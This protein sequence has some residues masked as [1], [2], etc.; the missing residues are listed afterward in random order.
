MTSAPVLPS[1]S[2]TL[3]LPPLGH[4]QPEPE[5]EPES[6]ESEAEPEE[7]EETVPELSTSQYDSSIAGRSSQYG[8]SIADRSVH[9]LRSGR[10]R[11]AR[12]LAR[13]QR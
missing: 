2:L 6:E 10:S 9:R 12:L 8:S 3:L 7:D 11:A 13:Q 1:A 4:L 5:S